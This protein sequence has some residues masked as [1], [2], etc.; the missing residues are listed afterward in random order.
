M[1]VNFILAWKIPDTIE[2]R[3]IFILG[4]PMELIFSG[5]VLRYVNSCQV[6]PCQSNFIYE[7]LYNSKKLM[8]ILC[9]VIV[10]S[11]YT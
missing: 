11:N 9:K 6:I 8:I 5:L 4:S 3:L 1:S 7:Q 2:Y 10:Q